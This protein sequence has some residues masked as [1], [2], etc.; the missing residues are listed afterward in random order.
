MKI[1]KFSER[2]RQT[3]NLAVEE[4][5]KLGHHYIGTEHILLGLLRDNDNIAYKILEEFGI[6][7]APTWEKVKRAIGGE[8]SSA[9]SVLGKKVEKLERALRKL[10]K[11]IG[12]EEEPQ[13]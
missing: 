5:Q 9:D 10:E 7:Y 6:S 3:L 11:R 1:E 4:A 2:A 12:L 13:E 8:T